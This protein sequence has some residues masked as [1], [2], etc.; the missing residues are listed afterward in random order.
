M[1]IRITQLSYHSHT[2][3]GLSKNSA[4]RTHK[5]VPQEKMWKGKVKSEDKQ[6]TLKIFLQKMTKGYYVLKRYHLELKSLLRK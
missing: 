5:E 1:G 6:Q 3:K 4:R 2:G